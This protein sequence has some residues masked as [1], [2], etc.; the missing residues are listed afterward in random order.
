MSDRIFGLIVVLVA[1]GYGLSAANIQESFL[2]DPMGPKAFP[3]LI[4]AVCAICGGFMVLR[5]DPEPEWP[6]WAVTG[7]IAFA[8]LVLVAYA[9]LLRPLGFLLPTAIAAAVVS[10]LIRPRAMPAAL[11]GVGLSVGL[12]V[13]FKYGLGLGL[14][15]VPRDWLG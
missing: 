4:A 5:P 12:F 8:V 14:F 15:A 1:L 6:S 10:Y 11:T 7:K 9:E 2:S 13:V 3:Y